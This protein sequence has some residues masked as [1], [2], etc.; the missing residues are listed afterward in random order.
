MLG[1][2]FALI[3]CNLVSLTSLLGQCPNKDSLWK[4][5]VY[6]TNSPKVTPSEQLSEL[7]PILDKMN[8]CAY[9]DDST[10]AFLL[11]RVAAGYYLQ[12]DYLNA[13]RYFRE[14]ITMITDN[15]GKPNVK[16]KDLVPTYYFLS[17]FYAALHNVTEE[18]KAA[19]SCIAYGMRLNMPSD[20]SCVAA[21]YKK[22][23]YYFDIGDYHR[24]IDYAKMCEKFG[25]EY[26]SHETDKMNVQAGRTSVES[27]LLWRVK[28]LLTLKEYETAEKLLSNKFEEYK[29][30]GLENYFGTLYSQLAQVQIYKGNYKQALVF[31]NAAL[32]YDHQAGY[33][34]NCKQTS[35]DIA[36]LY[37]K[38]FNDGDKALAYY[39][40]ALE[41]KNTDP[42]RNI[43][44]LFES[45]NIYTNIA[46][47]YVGKGDFASAKNYYQLAFDQIKP[48]INEKDILLSSPA[49]FIKHKKIFYLTSLLIDKA[50]AYKEQY[51]WNKQKNDLQEAIRIYKVA[52]R[53]LDKIKAEQTE[54]ESKL[55]WRTD[56][57]RLYENA[58]EACFLQDDLANAFYFFEKSR[59][60]LLNDQI[61]ERRLLGENDISKLA[62]LN[63]KI[64]LAQKELGNN[65][66]LPSRAKELQTDLFEDKQQ[67]D[68]LTKSVQARNPLYYQGFLDTSAI[69]VSDVRKRILGNSQALF[70]IFSGDSAV[71]TL[72][73]TPDRIHLDRINKIVYDSLVTGYINFVSSAV[74]SNRS[75]DA[76]V[77]TS[78]NL[79]RLLFQNLSFSQGR[80]IVSPDGQYF[81]FEA[82][83]TST[84]KEEVRYFISDHAV[85]YTHSA[86]Y[87]M[88]NFENHP[89]KSVR[90][91]LGIAPVHYAAS[92]SLS[93]LTGSDQSCKQ[94]VSWF[95][96]ADDLIGEEASRDKFLAKFYN[97]KIIQL[98]THAAGTSNQNEPV[99]YFADSALYLSD[100][101]GE[102]KPVTELVVLSACESGIG[103]LYKG[104]GLFSFNRGFAAIGIPSCITN[105][106]LAESES[107]YNITTL[108][109][110]YVAKGLPIDVALQR[111]KLEF[112]SAA[113]KE[114]RLPYYWAVSVL[115]GKSDAIEIKRAASWKVIVLVSLIVGAA[116]LFL[117]GFLKKKS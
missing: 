48:G 31:Y 54:L 22:V 41:Y 55:F 93:P 79:Y 83:V 90:N 43:A 21:L 107:T 63:K 86:R 61:N 40:N 104:E 8:T 30:N 87:L 20:I 19:D 96:E 10:H 67:L 66:L 46:D 112:I 69:S 38:Y 50:D 101:I 2:I 74:S 117:G 82:L 37:F 1:K 115:V 33:N 39:K 89:N 57:R 98:Y 92:M 15:A 113:S 29:K 59:A 12:G 116:L 17:V 52:D 81:P 108:F 80:I 111:A 114:K 110:K 95:S 105:L 51:R 27:S 14:S 49:E 42:R 6:F 70:E 47:V 77:Q 106:W 5:L 56:T 16:L 85:S 73:I 23:E 75:F 58:I 102:A 60:V 62:R 24:C 68:E 18:M 32:K 94:L 9:K 72:M 3:L 4:R 71:Y 53:L 78:Q 109:Y 13:V 28:A 34:F 97:Y 99:I 103:K 84:S 64:L 91:F 7:L 76:F 100:L 65:N 26:A 44:D 11:R 36:H 45:L 25:S 88:N 35:K